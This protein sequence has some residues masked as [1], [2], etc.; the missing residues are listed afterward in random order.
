MV[1]IDHC[2]SDPTC[3]RGTT[4]STTE[5][6]GLATVTLPPSTDAPSGCITHCLWSLP[7]LPSLPQP[8]CSRE[9]SSSTGLLLLSYVANSRQLFAQTCGIRGQTREP[10]PRSIFGACFASF[11]GQMV[12]NSLLHGS[13]HRQ[14]GFLTPPLTHVAAWATVG[15]IAPYSTPLGPIQGSERAFWRA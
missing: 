7:A 11:S 15:Q 2:V 10:S 4:Q 9:S 1:E 14:M 12:R 6:S 3:A 5:H 8:S 13:S